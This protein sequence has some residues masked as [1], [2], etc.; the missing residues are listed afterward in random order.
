ML[1]GLVVATWVTVLKGPM[2]GVVNG[3]ALAPG[4]AAINNPA[5][6]PNEAVTATATRLNVRI[7]WSL[8]S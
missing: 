6:T 8:R 3:R 2:N 1:A 4:T 7:P 5:V